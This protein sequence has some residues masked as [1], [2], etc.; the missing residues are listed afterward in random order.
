M[1]NSAEKQ[2]YVFG[3]DFWHGLTVL[4]YKP[5]EGLNTP[6]DPNWVWRPVVAETTAS[7]EYTV[8]YVSHF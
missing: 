3:S 6:R 7:G 2:R 4:A 1:K 8:G 5:S